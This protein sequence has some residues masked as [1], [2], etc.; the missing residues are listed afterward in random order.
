MQKPI[1]LL[2]S[3]ATVLLS[4]TACNKD[5]DHLGG[6]APSPVSNSPLQDLFTDH[7][8]QE[9]QTFTVNATVGG[10]VTGAA[11][12]RILFPANGFRDANGNVV[13]GTVQVQLLEALTI[14]RMIWINTQ[15]VGDDNGTDRLLRSGGEMRVTASQN[16]NV[17]QL[18]PGGMNVLMPTSNPD[19]NMQLFT[20]N[21]PRDSGMVWTPADSSWVTLVEDT[22]FGGG[23]SYAFQTDSLQWI[24]CDYFYNY[25]STTNIAAMIP[26]GQPADS[27]MVWIGFPSENA[28]MNMWN[29]QDQFFTTWQVVPVGM[30]ATVVGLYRNGS[31]YSS[32]FST[33][34]ITDLMT[35]PLTFTPTTLAQFEQDIDGI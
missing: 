18:G 12:T 23:P 13:S 20:A 34:T 24:N 6:P 11:G 10:L 3:A 8:T 29:N 21:E 35:V 4:I 19:N 7:I 26:A 31:Q 30:Q 9:T 1:I 5:D 15:T 32:A 25:P 22:A 14:G 28:V 33:V 16:G 27:T 17:L 2:A